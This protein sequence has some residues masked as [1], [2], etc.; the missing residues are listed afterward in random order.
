MSDLY[1]GNVLANGIRLHYYRTGGEGDAAKRPV[2]LCHGFSDDALCYS[3]LARVLEKDYDVVMVDA[4]FHGL[5]EAPETNSE[6]DAMSTDLAALIDA[7]KLDRPVCVGHSM[8]A[9]YVFRAAALYPDHMRAIVLEDP[10]WIDN[11][12]SRQSMD[13]EG[14]IAHYKTISLVD[15]IEEH[16]QMHPSWDEETLGLFSS[17]KKKLDP[18]IVRGE[19]VAPAS[20]RETLAEIK[21]P[22]LT[23]TAEPELGAIVTSEVW[24]DAVKINS[25]LEGAHVPGAGH[26]IRYEQEEA[27]TKAIT[28]FSGPHL[29]HLDRQRKP[30]A[31]G[32]ERIPCPGAF[33][34]ACLPLR[35]PIRCSVLLPPREPAHLAVDERGLLFQPHHHL[36]AAPLGDGHPDVQLD[37]VACRVEQRIVAASRHALLVIPQADGRPGRMTVVADRVRV[38]LSLDPLFSTTRQRRAQHLV[39]GAAHLHLLQV[40]V[41]QPVADGQRHAQALRRVALARLEHIAHLLLVGGQSQIPE[42]HVAMQH[43]ARHDQRSA[44]AASAKVVVKGLVDSLYLDIRL[45]PGAQPQRGHLFAHPPHDVLRRCD[46]GLYDP[47]RERLGDDGVAQRHGAR[48][49]GHL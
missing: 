46:A 41:L 20:W 38:D 19:I 48:I 21:C 43:V 35:Q 15:L 29:R 7:L 44:L 1:E 30:S 13:R 3:V 47:A 16:R 9:A 42:A 32:W 14:L 39:A 24:A 22:I 34:L 6:P 49:D 17:A 12:A 18:G 33:V 26:H 27:F 31:G 45:E 10:V 8:G 36:G 37:R 5:S 25:Q 11:F 40:D 2:V 28:A 4:R 23:F